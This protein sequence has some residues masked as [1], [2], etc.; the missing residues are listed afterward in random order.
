M[1]TV[2]APVPAIVVTKYA[3]SKVVAFVFVGS[4]FGN[5]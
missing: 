2:I 5:I 1:L 4:I 3:T